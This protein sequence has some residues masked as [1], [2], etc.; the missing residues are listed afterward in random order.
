MPVGHPGRPGGGIARD[1]ASLRSV[2][3]QDDL[4]RQHQEELVFGFMPVADR[5]CGSGGQTFH[6][7]PELRQPARVPQNTVAIGGKGNAQNGMDHCRLFDK[8]QGRKPGHQRGPSH[9]VPSL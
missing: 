4:T 7:H 1:K 2:F 8:G 5:G 9:G 3:V 6:M